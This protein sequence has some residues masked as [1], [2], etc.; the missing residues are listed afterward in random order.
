MIPTLQRVSLC[1][2]ETYAEVALAGAELQRRRDHGHELLWNA[3]PQWRP[4][5]CPVLFPIVG[6]LRC[7]RARID[8]QV[9][10]MGTHGFAGSQDFTLRVAEDDR[11]NRP[12]TADAPR[13]PGPHRVSTGAASRL[14][15]ATLRRPTIRG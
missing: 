11:V 4:R 2:G 12:P 6:R 3:D 14:A 10:E 1:H 9:V 13:P 15:S 5:C 7:G 8:R